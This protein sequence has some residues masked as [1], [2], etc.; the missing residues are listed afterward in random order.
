MSRNFPSRKG[1]SRQREQL[2]ERLGSFQQHAVSRK[3]RERGHEGPRS[4]AYLPGRVWL[5][6]VANEAALPLRGSTGGSLSGSWTR[7]T[8]R[9]TS[10]PPRRCRTLAAPSAFW[11]SLGSRTLL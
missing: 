4:Q 5:G 9:F 3:G 2:E 10:P 8:Q 1:C 6:P 7:S 11:T